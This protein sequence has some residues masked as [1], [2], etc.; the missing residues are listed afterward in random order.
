MM[1]A[2]QAENE[3]AA[4]R[5]P[6]WEHLDELRRALIK[7]LVA[8]AL[9]LAVT[10]NYS[11]R[12]VLFL[13]KP[14]LK[15]LPPDNQHLYYTGIADKFVI[16]FKVS[17]LASLM[18]TAPFL[19]YQIWT[20]VSPALYRN[21]RRFVGPFVFLGTISFLAGLAFSYYVVIPYG[22]KF[23]IEFG[24][25][26]D[27]AIITLTEYFGMTL[28]LMLAMGLVFELPVLMMLLGKFGIISAGFLNQYRRHAV[29]LIFIVSAIATP[30]PDAFTMLIVAVPL[31]LLYELS[32]L[33]VW[34][35]SRLRKKEE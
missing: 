26:T 15:I 34:W 17:V 12:I 8:I 21:E 9:G 5:M 31:W 22:Y 11:D 23:L 33:G 25:D 16:Y 35:V 14:L 6:L 13:Q 24:G 3:V 28:K 7:S 29:L 19:L 32:I 18:I 10:Y 20:F 27:Q 1:D 2:E 30:S 4:S